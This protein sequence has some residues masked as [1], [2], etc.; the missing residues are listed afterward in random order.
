MRRYL[1]IILFFAVLLVPVVLRRFLVHAQASAAGGLRLVVITPDNQDIRREFARAFDRWHREKY[2]VGVTIDYRTPGGTNDIERQLISTYAVYRDRAGTLPKDLPADIDILFGGGDFSFDQLKAAGIFQPMH[3]DPALLHAAFPSNNLAGVRLYD[4]NVDATGE[5]APRWVGTCLS[6]FGIIYNPDLYRT[7]QLPPPTSWHDLTDPQ[8]KGFIGLADPSHSGSVAAALMMVLQRAMADAEQDL[9]A[10]EPRFVTMAPADRKQ[11]AEYQ[12]AIGRGWKRGMEEL[13]LIAANARYFT[14]S[15]ETVP[16]DVSRGE[17]AAGMAIDFYA[18]VTED[19][20]GPS[21]ARFV[22]PAHATAIT[23]DPVAILTGVKGERL[24]LAM[25]FVEFLLSRQGQLLW[26]L[27]VGVPGGPTVR[28]LLRP[29]I[30]RDVYADRHGWESLENPFTEA[31]NFNQRGEWMALFTDCRM[32][33]VAAWIDSHDAMEEAYASVLS[34][35]DATIRASRLENFAELP[36]E[37]TDVAAMSA[38][39][40]A[41]PPEQIDLW[42]ARER[43]R[44]AQRFRE[45]YLAVEER[46]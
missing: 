9:F 5:P 43:I 37:M 21:R 14:D 10:N 29:P 19:V 2:G 7:L 16:T 17:A 42:R 30:R 39:R 36:I 6:G 23:P 46:K 1:L 18:H 13:T 12:A 4:T 8:L 40:K 34:E 45:H 26:A 3:L 24:E 22:L 27:P 32:I 20:V 44:W 11:N 15:A 25:H 41:Q 35:P 33:W 28:G 38:Q 31:G